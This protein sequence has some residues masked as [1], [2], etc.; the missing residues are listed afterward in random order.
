ME[1]KDNKKY[2]IFSIVLFFA[3]V[4]IIIFVIIPKYAPV[5]PEKIVEKIDFTNSTWI[6]QYVDKSVGL[7]G[8]DFFQNTAFSYN[9]RSNKMVVT[10]ASKKSVEEARNFYLALPEARET[11]R[12]D[13]T[14]LN[15]TAEKDGQIVQAYNY[16]SPIAR[17]FE[18]ELT[19]DAI[20]AS[21]VKNQLEESFPVD[22][23]GKISEIKSL[24]SGETFGGYVRY[25]YDNL[26]EYAYPNIPIFSRA[27]VYNGTE[28]DFN[29]TINELNEA[30]PTN[31]F[32]ETQNT[33]YYQINGNIVSISSFVTDAYENI[34][35]VGI[36][37]MDNQ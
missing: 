23:L 6:E 19:L 29:R 31:K 1:N 8:K 13:E 21:K 12:N 11:G 37:K 7:F 10:Y 26:D 4:A 24:I 28:E 22:E 30:Y 32:D 17:V 16:Y 9:K 27:Y 25:R 14:S 5:T 15:I 18:L 35:S 36:Q 33:H 2:T 20:N 3:I 34:V